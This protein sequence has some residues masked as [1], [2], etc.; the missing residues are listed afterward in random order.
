MKEGDKIETV[1][2]EGIV[3]AILGDGLVAEVEVITGDPAVTQ[4]IYVRAPD[5][6]A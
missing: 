3:K 2:G 6:G 1:V 5:G 4:T